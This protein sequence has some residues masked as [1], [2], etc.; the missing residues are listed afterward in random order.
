MTTVAW[1]VPELVSGSGGL[2]TI[3]AMA[4]ALQCSGMHT[5]IYLENSVCNPRRDIRARFGYEFDE[6]HNGWR[7]DPDVDIAIA[8]VWY[9]APF[10]AALG[11]RHKFYFVQDYEADFKPVGDAYLMAENTYHLNLTVI[12]MGRWLCQKIHGLTGQVCYP[13]E[14]GVDDRVYKAADS[15]NQKKKLSV[16][17]INQPEKPRRCSQLGQEALALFKQ[18]NPEVEVCLYGSSR[19]LGRGIHLKHRNLGMLSVAECARLYRESSVGLCISATNPSRIPFEMMATGLP[20]VDVHRQ[21]NLYDFESGS[22]LLAEQTP[23]AIAKALSMLIR[24][25]EAR[26]RRGEKSADFM[27][28]RNHEYEGEQFTGIINKV[29]GGELQEASKI[30]PWY[31]DDAV[32]ASLAAT[33]SPASGFGGS[34]WQGR[35]GAGRSWYF[36]LLRLLPGPLA[37]HT[38]RLLRAMLGRLRA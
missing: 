31:E 22:V 7:T 37:V 24:D 16:C 38:D 10:V 18:E 4:D 33:P 19:G 15:G 36:R 25:P 9:S 2:R 3:F 35:Q 1:Y 26:A 5:R 28:G 6:V 14:F 34:G 11:C 27:L 23:E 13:V 12:T 29:L 17:F 30:E 21:N 20:V 32:T 8:S